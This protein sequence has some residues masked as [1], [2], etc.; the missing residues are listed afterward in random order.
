MGRDRKSPKMAQKYRPEVIITDLMM[1]LVS[2]LDL[3][4]LIRE[5]PEL[6]GT[7]VI[8]LTAKADEDTRLEGVERGADAYLSKPFNDRE[9]LA[10]VKNLQS[11]KE[12]ERRVAE[13]NRYLTESV[14][15]RFLPEAMVKKAATGEL[16]L[17]LS[18]EPRLIT[19]LFSDIVGFTKMSNQLQSQGIA[20]VLNEYLSEM[21]R[22]I[23][24]NGGTVDKFVG[25]AVM[26][27]YGAP[28]E[29]PPEKQVQLAVKSAREML[30]S[31]DQLNQR[32]REQGIVGENGV[33]PVRFRCGIHIGTAVV[34]MFGS[35]ER[36]DYTAIGPAVNMAARLQEVAHPNSI[37]VSTEVASYLARHETLT[38]EWNKL[39]GIG[40]QVLTFMISSD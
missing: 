6:K 4:R 33:E 35:Q 31:L 36:S 3:I 38:K 27:L 37:L 34:G 19:I 25:D 9:L 1:P 40:D 30:Q 5:N 24:A 39:K 21:T 22:V 11:L 17:D 7:P 28:E 14:L 2:G 20:V 10:E 8:L 26:A 15:K 18:P 29:L 12:N 32:W 16:A 13:L 23:F